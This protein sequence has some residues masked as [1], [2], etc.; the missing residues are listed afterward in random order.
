MLT[1][2]SNREEWDGQGTLQTRGRGK[3]RGAYNVLVRKPEGKRPLGK[4]RHRC[5]P[6]SVEAY[7]GARDTNNIIKQNNNLL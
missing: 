3:R 5:A 6:P 1:G 4:S 2:L 7:R